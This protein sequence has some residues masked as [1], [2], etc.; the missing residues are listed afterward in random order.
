MK[1]VEKVFL[2]ILIVSLIY[3]YL[4]GVGSSLLLLLSINILAVFYLYFSFALLNDIEFRKI[5]KKASYPKNVRKRLAISIFTGIAISTSLMGI[6]FKIQDYPGADLLSLVSLG[7]TM[8]LSLITLY[9]NYKVDGD[10]YFN[11]F[12]RVGI[13]A[14]IIISMFKIPEKALLEWQYPDSPEYIKAVIDVRNN[15]KND[16]LQE[17]KRLEFEKMNNRIE[18][19]NTKDYK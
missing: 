11:V 17:I 6:L 8:A 12:I 13:T 9:K 7:F 2:I 4:Y 5:F 19:K 14:L 10:F 18:N 16:S 15:P 3:K 1:R